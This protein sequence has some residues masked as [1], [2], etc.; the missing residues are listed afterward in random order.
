M[1]IC[2]D[3]IAI[4]KKCIIADL[5]LGLLRIG[6][7]GVLK[8]LYELSEKFETIIIAGDVKH[9]NKNFDLKKLNDIGCE[10]VIVKGNHDI[11]IQAEKF[12]IE[13]DFAV[14]HGHILPE[15]VKNAK[16]WIVGHAHPS[17]YISD[18]VGG[19]KERAFLLGSV[20]IEG[21]KRD[22]VVLPAF[23][24]LCASTAVNLERP[25]GILFKKWDYSDWNVI[26]EDGTILSLKSLI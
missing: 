23:N 16:R 6:D 12:F 7:S 14:F 2:R 1:R 13:R 24:E 11:Y 20:E 8:K 22:V 3:Y 4:G 5:H 19:F 18:E 9:F 26:L 10:V 21:E 17:V 15:E 25:A